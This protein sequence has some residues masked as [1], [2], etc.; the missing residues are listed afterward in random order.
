MYVV[1]TEH[2]EDNFNLTQ[3]M[4]IYATTK[5]MKDQSMTLFV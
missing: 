4:Y 2:A 5:M 1:K 3:Y